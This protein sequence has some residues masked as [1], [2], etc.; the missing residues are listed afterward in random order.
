M[1][2][3]WRRLPGGRRT[4]IGTVAVVLLAV[5]G[6][7]AWWARAGKDDGAAPDRTLCWST[8][9]E[10]DVTGLYG[11][12]TRIVAEQVAPRDTGTTR[13]PY[14]GLCR[15]TLFRHGDAVDDV[16]EFRLHQPDPVAN[17]E[18]TGWTTQFL[19]PQG[20]P[21]GG[22]TVGT[23]SEARGWIALPEGCAGT[24]EDP[25]VVVDVRAGDMLLNGGE[26][27]PKRRDRLAEL[28]VR[29]ANGAMRALGCTE[30]VT[31]PDRL[32]PSPR[33][34][35]TDTGRLCGVAG[36]TLP[37]SLTKDDR[38]VL[39]GGTLLAEAAGTARVC[40]VGNHESGSVIRLST[41]ED[42]RLTEFHAAFAG[43]GPTAYADDLSSMIRSDLGM[44]LATCR[45]KEVAF[46]VEDPAYHPGLIRWLLPRY[47]KGE[48]QRLG[49]GALPVKL[50]R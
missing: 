44:V 8:L 43:S 25:P 6:S 1:T 42:P 12:G 13:D 24:V 22:G 50:P 38:H 29:M 35:E 39:S 19:S 34:V 4:V 10:R 28:T 41:I 45:G 21:F 18:A 36:L 33:V 32:R 46:V 27:R 37:G 16:L 5:C 23:V 26:P 14:Y 31:V 40:G 48:A 7:V 9:T 17:P 3:R 15:V 49:C 20:V 2:E 30:S 47:V 11:P